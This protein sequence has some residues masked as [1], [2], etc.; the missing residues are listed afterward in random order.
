MEKIKIVEQV[1]N[2][3]PEAKIQTA[4]QFAGDIERG[5]RRKMEDEKYKAEDAKYVYGQE[6]YNA[7]VE[8]GK[9]SIRAAFDPK[10]VEATA[11]AVMNF[12]ERDLTRKITCIKILRD[13][14]RPLGLIEA[15]AI[16]DMIKPVGTTDQ[17]DWAKIEEAEKNSPKPEPELATD[18]ALNALR[19]KLTT[20]DVA[21]D[22]IGRCGEYYACGCCKGCGC[23]C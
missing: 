21:I 9:N 11:W 1:G 7:G 23:Q 2:Y 12:T 18:S 22:S 5:F 13:K 3:F 20:N 17:L 4:L 19:E 6:Q 15:K 10:V 16:M 14:F 8:A